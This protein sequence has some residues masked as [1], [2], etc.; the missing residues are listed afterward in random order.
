MHTVYVFLKKNHT[1]ISIDLLQKDFLKKR[2]NFN[3]VV[4]MDSSTMMDVHD[5]PTWVYI[6]LK[7]K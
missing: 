5:E 6:F 7:C 3:S 2:F 1:M 4:T